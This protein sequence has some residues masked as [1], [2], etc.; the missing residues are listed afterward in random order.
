MKLQTR[1]LLVLA[2]IWGIISLAIFFDSQFTL[3]YS[4]KKLEQTFA[5]KDIHRVQKALSNLLAIL[6]VYTTSY[7]QWDDLYNFMKLKDNKFI[8]TNFVPAAYTAA[9]INFFLV[10]DASGKFFYG[11]EFNLNTDQFSPL[12]PD[13]MHKLSNNSPFVIHK[14]MQSYQP[15]FISTPQGYVA[16]ASLPILNSEA[17]GPPNGSLLMGYYLTAEHIKKLSETVEMDVHIVPLPLTNNS[18]VLK[19]AYEHLSKGE[20]YYLAAKDSQTAFGFAFFND[21]NNK[22]IGIIQVV[23]PRTFY[24]EGMS[25]LSRYATMIIIL[26]III[27]G[28]LW[29]LLR[30]FVLDRIITVSH[31]VVD[32]ATH[33]KFTNRVTVSGKDEIQGMATSINAMLELIE[34]TQDQLKYRISKRTKELDKLSQLNRNLF[35]EVSA[36][37]SIEAKLR[38]DEKK[39]RHM[40]YYDT[41]TGVPNRAFFN[42]LLMKALTQAE[43]NHSKLAILFIDADKFKQIND[44]H[45]HETGD[46]F[47]QI[48]SHRLQSAI[49]DT[50]MAGRL[51]GDEFILF[52]ANANDKFSLDNRINILYQSLSETMLIDHVIISPAFSIGIS[53]YPDDGTTIVDLINKADLAMYYAKKREGNICYYQTI[54]SEQTTPSS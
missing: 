37:K 24:N 35:G 20:S 53:I 52:L 47:L 4:Y 49:K 33:G 44:T 43:N 38:E 39:L 10:Y 34:L 54:E 48:M 25:A 41:L 42:E 12:S 9:K 21:I 6:E 22:P 19:N 1:V 32:I 46:K 51:A 5:A 36:Q 31:Q 50:D 30:K 28:T 26:G 11:K 2:S 40:A 15:G 7:S 16:M 27:L 8:Q 23:L 3:E 13:L 29:Y 17:K 18:P 45:G 14:N